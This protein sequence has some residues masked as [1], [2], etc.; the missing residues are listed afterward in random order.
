MSRCFDKV[1]GY[2][3][4]YADFSYPRLT[5]SSL[6]CIKGFKSV[7]VDGKM[8]CVNIDECIEGIDAKHTPACDALNGICKDT[9]GSYLCDCK[10]GFVRA[11]DGRTCIG[12]SSLSTVYW[13]DY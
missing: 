12:M 7:T 10:K 1:P 8:K 6:R 4:K 3:C 2:V 5:F 11:T 9:F 13:N